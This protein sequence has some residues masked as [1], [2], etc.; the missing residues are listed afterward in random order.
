MLDQEEFL[1]NKRQVVYATNL[2]RGKEALKASLV[3][4]DG[5]PLVFTRI[6]GKN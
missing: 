4:F 3:K 6:L 2:E 1:T 5:Q